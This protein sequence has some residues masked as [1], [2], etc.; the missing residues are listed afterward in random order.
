M[1][2]QGGK[3]LNS[4]SKDFERF[5]QHDIDF[6]FFLI[7]SFVNVWIVN[8]QRFS[9]HIV[10]QYKTWLTLRLGQQAPRPFIGHLSNTRG[11]LTG[12][13][14]HVPPT[15]SRLSTLT[16][17]CVGARDPK[18]TPGSSYATKFTRTNCIYIAL[19]TS[20]LAQMFLGVQIK[21]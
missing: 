7:F 16:L 11:R 20:C 21:M 4:R 8:L 3:L 10:H 14:L 18:R 15:P 12:L 2:L 1:Y 19:I 6:R 17:N 5:T 9:R 13:A